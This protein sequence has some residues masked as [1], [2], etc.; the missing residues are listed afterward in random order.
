MSYRMGKWLHILSYDENWWQEHR[1]STLKKIR[2]RR[3]SHS[4][5]L[6]STIPAHARP[7]VG[8]K[9]IEDLFR[10][11]WSDGCEVLK[12]TIATQITGI[13]REP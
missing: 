7:V 4:D 3:S 2:S 13:I 8:R 10:D 9:Q 6:H 1:G 11:R 5:G 12:G